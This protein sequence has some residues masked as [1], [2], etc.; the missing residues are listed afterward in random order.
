MAKIT[1]N[2]KGMHC[3]SCEVLIKEVLMELKGVRSVDV[4]KKEGM[5]TVEYDEKAVKPE[6]FRKKIRAQGYGV[7]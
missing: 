7:T 5:V 3:E 6:E 1:M 4:S 2:V